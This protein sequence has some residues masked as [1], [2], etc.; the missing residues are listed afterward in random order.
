MVKEG[1]GGNSRLSTISS[2]TQAPIFNGWECMWLAK[3]MMLIIFCPGL[4]SLRCLFF[5]F[6]LNLAFSVD[7]IQKKLTLNWH[8]SCHGPTFLRTLLS[9][10]AH[11]SSCCPYLSITIRAEPC[12]HWLLFL[13]PYCVQATDLLTQVRSEEQWL[14]SYWCNFFNVKLT[15]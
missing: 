12:S 14:K 1:S 10:H 15:A 3:E 4:I 8:V 2:S 9:Y 5:L 6:F 11:H 13:F 7:T